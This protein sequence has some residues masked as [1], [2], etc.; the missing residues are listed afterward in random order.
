M[1]FR[2]VLTAVLAAAVCGPAQAQQFG[3]PIRWSPPKVTS[4][5]PITISPPK[6]VLPGLTQFDPNKKGSAANQNL[7]NGLNYLKG[8]VPGPRGTQPGEGIGSWSIEGSGPA[9][10]RP[11]G[12]TAKP[13]VYLG[14][15]P[16]GLEVW[17]DGATGKAYYRKPRA[18]EQQLG[19]TAPGVPPG[20]IN[21]D[22]DTKPAQ[23]PPKINGDRDTRPAQPAPAASLVYVGKTTDGKSV[24]KDPQTGQYYVR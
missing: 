13:D 11:L 17:R 9:P 16:Q 1:R 5:P 4:P 10:E 18:P 20:K 22:R 3:P 8:R 7:N 12:T 6:Q 24:Y 14:R 19:T 23:A 21:G 15:N 2:P